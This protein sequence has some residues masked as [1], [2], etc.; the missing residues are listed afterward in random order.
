M[1]N[2]EEVQEGQQEMEG[3]MEEEEETV[4]E[5]EVSEKTLK[6]KISTEGSVT[7]PGGRKSYP[8]SRKGSREKAQLQDYHHNVHDL[9]RA[10]HDQEK[11]GAFKDSSQ[12]HTIT[13]TSP[14]PLSKDRPFISPSSDILQR[15]SSTER[16]ELQGVVFMSSLEQ[17]TN[18][19][20]GELCN[21]ET[22]CFED[23]VGQVGEQLE[24][25]DSADKL[26]ID[27]GM[28]NNEDHDMPHEGK[29]T[30]RTR[31]RE[32]SA[33]K[34][35]LLTRIRSLT[36]RLSF[37]NEKH[38]TETMH[39]YCNK[40]SSPL[41]KL[42]GTSS[43]SV[44]SAD[45]RSMVDATNKAMTLPKTRKPQ[46]RDSAS[47]GKRGWKVLI[48]GGG[49]CHP[50]SSSLELLSPTDSSS[51]DIQQQHNKRNALSM[52]QMSSRTE[53]LPGREAHSSNGPEANFNDSED[54][55]DSWN[56]ATTSPTGEKSDSAV[57]SGSLVS[58]VKEQDKSSG[59]NNRKKTNIW[60]SPGLKH[61]FFTRLGRSNT[62]TEGTRPHG[63]EGSSSKVQQHNWMAS[64]QAS[65]RAKKNH[66]HHHSL[67]KPQGQ[68]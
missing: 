63:S 8:G 5:V 21:G 1:E 56:I 29:E 62:H 40:S 25:Q 57:L 19:K 4:T 44:N 13:P 46:R 6:F 11:N 66:H 32:I 27:S 34:T 28:L 61:G 26:G 51:P 12:T 35:T 67:K 60:S 42:E 31:S 45:M 52:S 33:K 10:I 20:V 41:N 23:V 37:S 24:V 30:T 43:T 65:F 18:R 55:D 14:P 50:P 36:D 59:Y 16:L 68:E 49:K 58:I 15:Q 22:K 2:E 54:Q 48:G 9:A 53:D 47:A 64:L 3:D 7:T 38:S 17:A 39:I